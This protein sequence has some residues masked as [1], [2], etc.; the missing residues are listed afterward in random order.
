M[1]DGLLTKSF[2]TRVNTSI[3]VFSVDI[4]N[5]D[6]THK[7]CIVIYKLKLYSNINHRMIIIII[8][9]QS[10]NSEMIKMLNLI[11]R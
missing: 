5:A 2:V 6:T 11:K 1:N 8:Y 9:E 3:N 10:N 4:C 7:L